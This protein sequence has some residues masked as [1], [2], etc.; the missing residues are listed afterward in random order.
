[1]KEI[2]KDIKGYNGLYQISNLGNVRSLSKYSKTN[3]KITKKLLFG[4]Y[5]VY[6]FNCK[7]QDSKRVNRLIAEAFIHNPLNK[8]EVNHI[9]GNKLDNRVE[10]LEWTTRKENMQHAFRKGLVKN[11]YKSVRAMSDANKRPIL[12]YDLNGNFIKEYSSILEAS[13]ELGISRCMIDRV[14]LHLRK[15]THK[16]IFVYK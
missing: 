11:N 8:K 14:L 12:Q 15:K 9:N 1:M 4:Y 10:N 2:W 5:Y 7:K 16:S 6:L 13:K 3:G